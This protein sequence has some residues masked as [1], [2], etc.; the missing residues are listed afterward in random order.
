MATILTIYTNKKSTDVIH[1]SRNLYFVLKSPQIF[2]HHQYIPPEI[3]G[4]ARFIENR[5]GTPMSSLCQELDIGWFLCGFRA[6]WDKSHGPRA[7]P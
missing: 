4:K 2:W 3:D 1:I 6:L 5:E 7:P